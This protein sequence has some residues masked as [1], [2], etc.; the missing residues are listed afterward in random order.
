MKH[1]LWKESPVP[2]PRESFLGFVFVLLT[3]R[4]RG[5]GGASEGTGTYSIITYFF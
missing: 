5:D 4:G 3:S 1:H 2:A